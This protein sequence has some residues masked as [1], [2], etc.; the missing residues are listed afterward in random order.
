MPI[1]TVLVPLDGSELAERA[2]HVV[3]EVALATRARVLVVRVVEPPS[4]L[5]LGDRLEVEA[6]LVREAE[7][8]VNRVA[9]ELRSVGISADTAV[10]YDSD[11]PGAILEQIGLKKP[12]LV[13][14][15]THG[16]SGLGRW[17]Y[18]SV[19]EGV[20]ARSPVPV[21]VIKAAAPPRPFMPTVKPPR[22]LV[23]LDGSQ[24]GE[25]AL[26]A[27]TE[28]ARIFEGTLVLVRVVPVS[29]VAL[30][31]ESP[32]AMQTVLD[33]ELK[34]ARDYL[35]GVATQLRQ[36]GIKAAIEIEVGPVIPRLL[37]VGRRVDADLIAISS[38]GR[39]G[40]AELIFGSVTLGLLRQAEVPLLVV[41]PELTV[42]TP[43]LRREPIETSAK[44]FEPLQVIELTGREAAIVE[45][46]LKYFAD[47]YPA[48]DPIRAEIKRIYEKLARKEPAV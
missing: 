2:L 31:P 15:S 32:I 12:D 25:A 36:Q 21:L 1:Q 5:T 34:A 28:L 9:E 3:R 48:G 17:I 4:L 14:M 40:L 41:R 10:P 39:T 45:S 7:D 46:A 42:Q 43:P 19:A 35:E 38:H 6:R 33:E 30:V 16:R 26:S 29:Q 11:V 8:Y 23:P 22:I 18:G 13:V 24:Y 27:A 20:L 37:E 44:Q 47:V